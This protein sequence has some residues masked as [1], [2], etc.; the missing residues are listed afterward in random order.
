MLIFF[1]GFFSSIIQKISAFLLYI[2]MCVFLNLFNNQQNT[3][4]IEKQ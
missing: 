2:Y 4:C 1:G 3:L